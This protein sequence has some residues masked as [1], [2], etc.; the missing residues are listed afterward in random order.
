[1]AESSDVAAV[2]RLMDAAF[3][4]WFPFEKF[5]RVGDV[6]SFSINSRFVQGL[7]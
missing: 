5:Y 4:A 1:M 2:R 7:I 6:N 3:P